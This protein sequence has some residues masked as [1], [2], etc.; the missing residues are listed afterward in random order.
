MIT[1]Q[2]HI[3]NLLQ[4]LVGKISTI[5]SV[6]KIVL[7][8]SRARGDMLPKSDIDVAIF[9]PT[10]TSRE[11]LNIV[12]MVEDVDTLLEFDLV[13]FDQ[14]GVDLQTQ[15]LKEGVML[16]ERNKN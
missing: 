11:W 12:D 14:A 9:C 13:R 6:Q 16:Y 7:F 5:P 1:V 4:V 15:I 8:G 10:A 2:K 3:D